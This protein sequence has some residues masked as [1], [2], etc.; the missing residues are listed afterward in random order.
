ML[1][2]YNCLNLTKRTPKAMQ[3]NELASKSQLFIYSDLAKNK[4]D[5][6]KVAKVRDYIN[7]I[8]SFKKIIE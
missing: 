2:V 3:K 1:F 7:N 8:D 5:F 4:N 6:K